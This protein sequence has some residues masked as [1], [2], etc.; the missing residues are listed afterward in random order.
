M[1]VNV[2]HSL[3]MAA[4]VSAALAT[5]APAGASRGECLQ[6]AQNGTQVDAR[7]K[8]VLY[9]QRGKWRA[10]W[11]ASG[12]SHVLPHQGREEM[13]VN[14]TGQPGTSKI[15]ARF[16]RVAGR[17]VAYP[18]LWK[19]R[20]GGARN[21][22][23]FVFDASS[24][25]M[26][27]ETFGNPASGIRVTSLVLKGNGSVAWIYRTDATTLVVKMD[28]ASGGAES[29]LDSN[30]S[31]YVIDPRSLVLSRSTVSWTVTHND[32]R[33]TLSAQLS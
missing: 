33:R 10:C 12:K 29:G 7:S 16:L 19:Q 14:G 32:E 27:Y 11:Y 2:R 4:I 23:V 1:R 31:G 15:D 13:S 26:K 18:V 21:A 8:L 5:A 9:K 25:A 22:R 20:N 3:V 6:R 24:G 17:H 30:N 28:T